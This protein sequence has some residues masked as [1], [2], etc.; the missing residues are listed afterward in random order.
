MNGAVSE[1][2]LSKLPRTVM[3]STAAPE[4]NAYVYV[5][6][7][8]QMYRV[9]PAPCG[10]SRPRCN[11]FGDLTAMR[12]EQPAAALSNP[13]SGGSLYSPGGLFWPSDLGIDIAQAGQE[14]HRIA[15][16]DYEK[17]RP[18]FSKLH[19]LAGSGF[20]FSFIDDGYIYAGVR[21]C[22]VDPQAPPT[23]CTNPDEK[24]Q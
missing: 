21:I 2:F 13:S 6:G 1:D 17:H 20:G 8:G 16:E 7:A 24:N 5:T 9:V 11:T 4:P 22:R 15:N 23:R 12:V 10:G 18:F 19:E 3:I 14:G